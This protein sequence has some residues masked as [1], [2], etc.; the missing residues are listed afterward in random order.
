MV[1]KNIRKCAV[2]DKIIHISFEKDEDSDE[3]IESS[4]EGVPVLTNCIGKNG[5]TENG[6]YKYDNYEWFCNECHK[7]LFD[8]IK[9]DP[10][11]ILRELE[12]GD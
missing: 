5:K 8:S 3:L 6:D 1:N 2:C 10:I 12:N 9:I 7:E 11:K 4:T